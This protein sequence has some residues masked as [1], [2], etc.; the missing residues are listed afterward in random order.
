MTS[1]EGEFVFVYAENTAVIQDKSTDAKLD[2]LLSKIEKM[3]SQTNVNEKSIPNLQIN[4]KPQ[5]IDNPLSFHFIFINNIISFNLLQFLGEQSA[6]GIGY[7][8]FSWEGKDTNLDAG[9]N[10]H[11]GDA[12]KGNTNTIFIDYGYWLRNKKTN[13]FNPAAVLIMKLDF[14]YLENIDRQISNDRS[15]LGLSL[16]LVNGVKIYKNIGATFGV[17]IERDIRWG[18]NERNALYEMESDIE[19]SPTLTIDIT[20]PSFIK[21]KP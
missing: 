3:E 6:V 11:Y 12:Y 17:L 8:S 18:F 20:F 1:Q 4:P 15:K 16:A 10:T 19:L 2:L 9:I 5:Q 13:L 14:I 7:A 21:K